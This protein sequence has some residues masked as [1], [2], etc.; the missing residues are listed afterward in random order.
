MTS[1]VSKHS[2]INLKKVC[3]CSSNINLSCYTAFCAKCEANPASHKTG[4]ANMC[5]FMAMLW[6]QKAVSPAGS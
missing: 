4:W 5:S 6:K 1:K 2:D 3:M